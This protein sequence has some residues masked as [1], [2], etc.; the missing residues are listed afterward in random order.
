MHEEFR[1][2][3]S[4]HAPQSDFQSWQHFTN[5]Q[6]LRFRSLLT[7]STT[8]KRNFIVLR[9]SGIVIVYHNIPFAG[10]FLI[11]GFVANLKNISLLKSS[12]YLCGSCRILNQGCSQP[13][14]QVGDNVRGRI[15]FQ[16][17]SK[18][19]QLPL[20]FYYAKQTGSSTK[21]ML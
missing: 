5:T 21:T 13:C 11:V 16:L 15:I 3:T 9:V 14:I 1:S 20:F 2:F 18:Y 4:P 6:S 8:V 7:Q 10:N 17:F 12:C 19:Y